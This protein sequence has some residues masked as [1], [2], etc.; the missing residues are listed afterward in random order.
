MDGGRRL[1]RSLNLA[2]AGLVPERLAYAGPLPG[3]LALREMDVPRRKP[4]VRKSRRS[5]ALRLLTR[6]SAPGVSAVFA[7]AFL[8]SVGL[9]GA[10]KGGEYQAF[11]T[12]EGPLPDVAAKLLGFGIKAV[13]IAG[14][15]ELTEPEILGQAGIGPR[16]SLLFLDVAQVRERLK[17]LPLIREVSVSKLYPNRLLIEVDERQAFALWQKNGQVQVVSGD[18][19]PIDAM[20]DDRFIH[21][22]LVVGTGANKKLNDYLALLDAAGEL[23]DRIRA[24]MLVTERR[25]TLQMT[26]GV[27]VLLPELDPQAA[28]ARLVQLQRD[29]RVLD[30]DIISLDFRQPGRIVARL[31]EDAANAR[32]EML[33]HKSKPKGGQT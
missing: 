9:Y 17:S 32:A 22:P 4:P 16:N 30:K 18:G 13:T 24:G 33:A 19:T 15:R 5:F 31:T 12:S 25:W 8:G 3:A 26:N 27:E 2:D 21:L 28:L 1:L 20:H 7:F 11:I 10:V 23:R 6:L 29:F 14:E